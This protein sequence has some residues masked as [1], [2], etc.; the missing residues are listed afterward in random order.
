MS[1]IY[2]INQYQVII[3]NIQI[4]TINHVEIIILVIFWIKHI[5]L[6]NDIINGPNTKMFNMQNITNLQIPH[7]KPNFIQNTII[8]LMTTFFRIDRNITGQ[9]SPELSKEIRK[10]VL[11]EIVPNSRAF[12]VCLF[13]FFICDFVLIGTSYRNSADNCKKYYMLIILITIEHLSSIT[14]RAISQPSMILMRDSNVYAFKI[15]MQILLIKMLY[16]YVNAIY[17]R[18]ALVDLHN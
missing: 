17:N 15:N 12:H 2:Y 10:S 3:Q 5:M 11:F 4:W 13:V 8:A 16:C 14:F 1:G 6:L 9:W 7:I 18:V